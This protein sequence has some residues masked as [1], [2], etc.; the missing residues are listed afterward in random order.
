MRG[1]YFSQRKQRVA[2]SQRRSLMAGDRSAYPS[3]PSAPSVLLC[4]KP[5]PLNQHRPVRRR[6]NPASQPLGDPRVQ[7]VTHA[8]AQ[9]VDRQHH[10]PQEQPR[11]QHRRQRFPQTAGGAA[12]AGA[13]STAT[14]AGLPRRRRGRPVTSSSVSSMPSFP[15]GR[16]T[17]GGPSCRSSPSRRSCSGTSWRSPSGFVSGPITAIQMAS[18]PGC[19]TP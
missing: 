1:R 2:R 15:R 14:L 10:R 8:I 4:E 5:L 7:H 3:A 16:A 9:D 6:S 17:R 13:D 11:E 18:D 12:G 19:L